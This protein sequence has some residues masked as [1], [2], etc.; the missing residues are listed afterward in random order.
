MNTSQNNSKSP[1][2]SNFIAKI[3]VVEDEPHLAFNLNLNLQ[4]EG[5]DCIIAN[6]GPTALSAFENKGPFDLIILDVMLPEI[7]GFEVAEFIRKKDDQTQILMLTAM[8]REEDR[9]RGLEA[10]A[11]DYITKPFHLKEFLLRVKRM[12]RRSSYFSKDLSTNS[13][14]MTHENSPP[15]LSYGPFL[16]NT[17]ILELT[18]EGKKVTLT[19]LETDV[20]KE[21]F[22]NPD[23]VLSR[24]YL[25]QKVWGIKGD[26]ETR[27][28]DNFI[29]RLRRYLES[30]PGKPVYLV[31]V[32][33][34]GYRLNK[35]PGT[36]T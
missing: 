12:I 28:V 26:I 18:H 19:A 23:R 30:D 16:L 32:R 4:A 20:L 29:V 15:P 14:N 1:Q 10:G 33:G 8:G 2:Q 35:M 5:F 22:L 34:R 27:T 9:I 24:A 31:S 7:S 3:L 36:S 25:L 13:I 6:D 21:F 11:D 17:E